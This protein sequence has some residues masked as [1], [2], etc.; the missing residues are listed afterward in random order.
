MPTINLVA[1]DCDIDSYGHHICD[2]NGF[3]SVVTENKQVDVSD[4]ANYDRI[5]PILES[6][7]VARGLNPDGS[8]PEL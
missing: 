7:R 2:A 4:Q 1:G 5:Q 3:A 6:Y 8:F